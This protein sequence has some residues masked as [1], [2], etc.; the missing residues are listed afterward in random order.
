M[1]VLRVEVHICH[2]KHTVLVV[3]KR[4]GELL[5]H[6]GVYVNLEYSALPQLG[7]LKTVLSL[8]ACSKEAHLRPSKT[9]LELLSLVALE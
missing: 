1:I 3:F 5:Q 8:S 4:I 2:T 9:S 7:C 6:R